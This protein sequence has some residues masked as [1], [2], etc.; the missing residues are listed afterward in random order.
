MFIVLGYTIFFLVRFF[1]TTVNKVRN[2]FSR[3]YE[4]LP[5]FKKPY[6]TSGYCYQVVATRDFVAGDGTTIKAGTV[7]GYVTKGSLAPGAWVEPGAVVCQSCIGSNII[8]AD[9][10]RVW[11]SVVVGH[12]VVAH[13]AS[14]MN[15]IVANNATITGEA[16]VDH[17]SLICDEAT[18]AQ[19]AHVSSSLVADGA[20][21]C[22]GVRVDYSRVYDVALVEGSGWIMKSV[23]YGTA[24]VDG[25]PKILN[26]RIGSSIT[27]KR[28]I[29]GAK[30]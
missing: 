3:Y 15:S 11:H 19:T 29:N 22:G 10:A 23:F 20:R 27:G 18:V 2:K 4:Y 14:V 13:S 12:A 7:G 9:K 26:S 25:S 21:V 17:G 6:G 30:L 1:I 16:T 24:H 8:V 28:Q 5:D